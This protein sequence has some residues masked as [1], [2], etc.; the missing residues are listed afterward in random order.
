MK[1]GKRFAPSNF[2]H[3]DCA[4]IMSRNATERPVF[5]LRQHLLVSV[6]LRAVAK[7]L[8]MGFEVRICF[9][10]KVVVGEKHVSVLDQLGEHLSYLTPQASPK[11]S[12][13]RPSMGIRGIIPAINLKPAA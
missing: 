11:K 1:F 12:D 6:R 13:D 10:R 7:M 8:S 9:G 2:C 5:R 3:F 4:E